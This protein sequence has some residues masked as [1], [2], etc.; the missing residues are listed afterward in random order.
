MDMTEHAC[1]SKNNII[2]ENRCNHG[3]EKSYIEK[4]KTQM[5]KIKDTSKWK[6][7]LCSSTRRINFVNMAI[8]PIT[9][10]C[11]SQKQKK[12]S[13]NSYGNIKEPEESEQS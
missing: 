13:L 10:K 5:K 6:Y 1:T 11:F 4:Y 7:I 12:K 3:G 9:L 8:I 2:L